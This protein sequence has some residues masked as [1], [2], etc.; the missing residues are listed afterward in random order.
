[1]STVV[2]DTNILL[3]LANPAAKEHDVCRGAFTRLVDAGNTLATAPQILVEFWVVAT[4]PT[5]VNG[6]GWSPDFARTS[7]DAFAEQFRLLVETREAFERWRTLVTEGKIQGK[8]AHD[9]RIAALM[10]S[11]GVTEL[12]TFN[13]DDFQN[14]PGLVVRHPSTVAA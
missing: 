12:V 2:L 1:M 13:T 11:S 3:R 10:L 7:V 9:A 6:L 14:M 4:R 8:R 5:D